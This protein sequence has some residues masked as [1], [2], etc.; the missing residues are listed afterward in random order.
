MIF[1]CILRLIVQVASY[2]SHF[3][4]KCGNNVGNIMYGSSFVF[5]YCLTFSE[6]Y[7]KMLLKYVTVVYF[8]YFEY[9]RIVHTHCTQC[10]D[11]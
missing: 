10:R 11:I 6:L 5:V 2:V 4:G 8:L 1:V 9:F 7:I 3:I